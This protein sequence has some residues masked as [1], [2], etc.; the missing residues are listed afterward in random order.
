MSTGFRL[1][2]QQERVWILN[3]EQNKPRWAE[4]EAL[5]EG[6]LDVSKLYQSVQSVVRR[7][8]ILRTAFR[9]R[10]ELKL[11]FQVIQ[12]GHDFAWQ[13][14]DLKGLGS[15]DQRVS[16]RTL[17]HTQRE[18]LS[19]EN[20]PT[21]AVTLALVAPETHVL[22]VSLPSLC[23]DL[24]GLWNL[25]TELGR[26]YEDTERSDVLQYVDFVEWQQEL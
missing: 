16:I 24:R 1:S 6:A 3:G 18:G 7:H 23:T 12:D 11:P 2:A 4:C 8:E 10:P 22:I 5:L 20:G 26:S 21:L 15:N 19:L 14:A 13:T 17:V 25:V 9:R